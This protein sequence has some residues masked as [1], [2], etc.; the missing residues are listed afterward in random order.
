M[1]DFVTVAKV[2]AIPE[3]QGGT[4]ASTGTSEITAPAEPPGNWSLFSE[5]L[6]WM[7]REFYGDLPQDDQAMS[8]AA[9]RGVLNRLSDRNTILVEPVAADREQELFD[10]E[11]GGVGAQVNT[12]E[13]GYLVIIAPIDG[14]PAARAD[15]RA[16]DIILQVDDTEI[17]GMTT[18]EAIQ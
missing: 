10:G 16:N 5:A 9:I 14:T 8:W 17:I 12:N 4:F 15:L 7:E 2:G 1:P 3:G 6:G 18:D 11:F 13:E